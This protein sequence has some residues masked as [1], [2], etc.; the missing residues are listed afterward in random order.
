MQPYFMPYLGY[1][2]LIANVDLFVIYDQIKYTKKGWINRNR[3]L[4]NGADTFITLPLKSD[5]DTLDIIDRYISSDFEPIKIIRQ[6]HGAYRSAPHVKEVMPLMEEILNFEDYN[7]F[8]FNYNAIKK[9]C[10]YLGI[11]TP[12]C[13]SS[14]ISIDTDLKGEEKVLAL[15]KKLGASIYVN[16]IGGLELY[17][18]RVFEESRIELLFLRSLPFHYEQLGGEFV[19]WLSIIDV[20][21]FNSRNVISNQIEYGWRYE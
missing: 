7:L 11:K 6:I 14:S 10:E 2:Q 12:I 17:D 8:R 1:Y 16:P 18:K 15:C 4:R 9:S 13:V 20:M 19:P 3:I 21:M 5:S